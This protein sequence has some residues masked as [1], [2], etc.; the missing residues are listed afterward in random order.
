MN[1]IA[2]F[3]CV[4]FSVGCSSPEQARS[5]LEDYVKFLAVNATALNEAIIYQSEMKWT[6]KFGQVPKL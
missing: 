6:P 4:I 5:K 3:L 2:L 1:R